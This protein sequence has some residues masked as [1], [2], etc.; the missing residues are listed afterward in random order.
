MKD[1]IKD[2]VKRINQLGFV[3][4]IRVT[5]TDESTVFAALDP[6][7]T[8]V[9]QATMLEPIEELKG[10]FGIT[11]INLLNGLI[12][13]ASYNTEDAEFSINYKDCNKYGPTPSE[14]VFRDKHGK[15]SNFRLSS[16]DNVP[17]QPMVKNVAWDTSFVPD[18]SKIQEFSSLASLY[19]SFDEHFSLKIDDGNLV[20]TIGIEGSATHSVSMILEEGVEGNLKPHPVWKAAQFLSVLKLASDTT[21]TVS[22]AER[23]VM[24][25]DMTTKY[26]NIKVYLLAQIR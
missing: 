23:G 9:I 3:E 1:A 18:K 12:G 2:V 15:G 16:R 8:V 13:F 26:A 5:G 10:E 11:A 22:V 7:K 21:Y 14:F 17:N 4:A 25:I 20:A 6:N 24:L 19:S